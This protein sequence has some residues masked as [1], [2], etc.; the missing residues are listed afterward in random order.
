MC[1]ST[2]FFVFNH[3]SPICWWHRLHLWTIGWTQSHLYLYYQ[4]YM[5]DV[6]FILTRGSLDLWLLLFIVG[7]I[8]S[9]SF[10]ALTCVSE[11]LRPT[12][13]FFDLIHICMNLILIYPISSNW[14]LVH[15]SLFSNGWIYCHDIL[16]I[17]GY[18]M[19]NVTG[20]ADPLPFLF[21]T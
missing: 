20:C 18:Q 4:S 9:G 10:R 14:F 15:L 6:P 16:H 2:C 11:V 7:W 13:H 3:R 17:Y 1:A 8:F 5:G 21:N 19:I 12:G